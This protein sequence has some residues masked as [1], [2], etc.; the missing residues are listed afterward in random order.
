MVKSSKR[1]IVENQKTKFKG[2]RLTTAFVA[3][4][5]FLSVFACSQGYLVPAELTATA[6]VGKPTATIP[7]EIPTHHSSPNDNNPIS[8]DPTNVPTAVDTPTRKSTVFIPSTPTPRPLKNSTKTP[9]ILYYTQAGDT[10]PILAIRFNVSPDEITSPQLIDP[11]KFLNPGQLLVIPNRLGETSSSTALI[12]DSEVVYSPSTLDFDMDAYVEKEGGHLSTYKEYLSNGWNSGAQ[13]IQRVAQEN[14]INPRVL[15]SLLEYQSH[16]VTAQPTNANETDYPLGYIEGNHQGL[17]KQLSWVVQQLSIGYYHWRAGDLTELKFQDGSKVKLAP[18]LN[19]GTVAIQYYF[20]T[21][22]TQKKWND[23]LY[24]PEGYPALHEKMFGNPW[25]RA[26]TVEPLFPPDLIQP[27]LEL[28]F[29]P[30]HTWSL[31]GGPHSAWGPD[32]ALSAIDLAPRTSEPGCSKAVDYVTSMAPG[33][34]LRAWNGQVIVDLDGDG[35]EQTGWV[36]LYMHIATRDRVTVGT[37]LN[38][39]DFIGWP[40]CEGGDATGTHTHIARKYNGEW[41]L[42]DGPIPLNIGGWITHRGENFYEGSLTNGD[43]VVTAC[44]CGSS[45]TLVTRPNESQ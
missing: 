1:G 17:F 40:S 19:A 27:K 32:G 6:Q 2:K 33:L 35:K 43:K 44:T 29:R 7:Q 12:P 14:S 18:G 8:V 30:G 36:I 4:V 26:Q 39:D 28:P 16:W 34:V 20:S 21:I 3:F 10:L 15:L 38:T 45:E 31:T 23:I 22:Y 11:K 24:E 13:V 9:T 5:W 25:V 41:M 37:W 42:A